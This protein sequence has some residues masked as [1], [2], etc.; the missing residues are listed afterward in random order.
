[1]LE[2]VYHQNLLWAGCSRDNK[3]KYNTVLAR[4]APKQVYA[5]CIV[6]WTILNTMVCA[7]TIEEMLEIKVIK[8]GGNEEV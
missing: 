4:L 5:L 2:R 1:M 7:E 3:K 6:D 8:M